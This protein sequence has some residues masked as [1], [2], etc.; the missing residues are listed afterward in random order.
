MTAAER[1]LLARAHE[2]ADAA[3]LAEE[4][5][6]II[7][8][9]RAAR[10][11]QTALAGLVTAVRLLD[12]DATA[13]FRAVRGCQNAGGFDTDTEL[14][15]AVDE[16]AEDLV[17]R[18]SAAA[19]FH[20]RGDEALQQARVDAETARRELARALAMSVASP[21]QGCHAARIG[22]I[23]DAER[24]LDDACE[25]EDLAVAAVE[26]L[27]S[28]ARKLPAALRAVR[29][30]PDD[31]REA[32]EAVYDLVTAD[33]QAMP[34]DGDFITGERTSAEMAARMLAARIRTQP[35]YP[36]RTA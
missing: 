30:V 29:R 12:G 34:E 14:L 3:G 36:A 13:L 27:A 31:L 26:I 19:Q 28:L 4:I 18:I 24:H 16:A 8:R 25:R 5:T 1:A 10:V 33:P 11:D 21:C 35:G 6:T 23:D 32:Y 9:A 17:A 7:G 15:E 2:L 20:C 22:A